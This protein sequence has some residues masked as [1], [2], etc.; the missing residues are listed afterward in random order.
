MIDDGDDDGDDG[1]DGGDDGGDVGGELDGWF[2]SPLKVLWSV[3]VRE[4]SCLSLLFG[5][6]SSGFMVLMHV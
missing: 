2:D 1:V 3:K 4:C 6:L 5:S